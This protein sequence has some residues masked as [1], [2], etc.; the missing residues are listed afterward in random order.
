L[1]NPSPKFKEK[2]S[3]KAKSQFNSGEIPTVKS[4]DGINMYKK[5]AGLKS[6]IKFMKKKIKLRDLKLNCQSSKKKENW[7][8]N[9]KKTQQQA[10]NL[11]QATKR[12]FSVKTQKI[13][14]GK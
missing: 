13:I 11:L 3:R 8:K 14:Q 7:L 10:I 12:V 2:S 4:K 5:K 9:K 6:E 1:T